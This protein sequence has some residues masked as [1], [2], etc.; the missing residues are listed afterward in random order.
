[1][2][3]PTPSDYQEAVQNP[4][5]NFRDAELCRA[6]PELNGLGLPRPVSGGFASVYRLHTEDRDWAVR[7]FLK[8]V[9]N[10]QQRYQAIHAHL[11]QARLPYFVESTYLPDGIRVMGR[12]YPA[13]KMAWVRGEPL[14]VHLMRHLG[15]R[16][17]LEGLANRWL[18]LSDGLRHAGIAHGDL[19]HGNILVASGQFQLID[20]DGMFVPALQGQ[21]SHEL[22][23]RHYQ[24]PLRDAIQFDGALDD[25]SVW[26]IFLSILA[27]ARLPASWT[28][29]GAGDD[30]LLFC[31]RDFTDA[32]DSPAFSLLDQLAD[33]ALRKLARTFRE[34]L[35]G[36][37]D[38]PPRWPTAD[39]PMDAY[40]PR[41]DPEKMPAA[42]ERAGWPD[43]LR[44]H[45]DPSL[46]PIQFDR[47]RMAAR[48]GVG[49]VGAV[50][51]GAGV[52][53]L[54]GALTPPALF[55]VLVTL[56]TYA[57]LA[58]AWGFYRAP[59][60]NARRTVRAE[61]R[62]RRRDLQQAEGK[63]AALARQ[64]SKVL[65]QIA[66][67]R[68]ASAR[69][70]QQIAH[71]LDADVQKQMTRFGHVED[72]LRFSLKEIAGA[73][74]R[75]LA[76]ALEELRAQRIR[77]GLLQHKLLPGR[78]HGVGPKLVLQLQV[79]GVRSARDVNYERL[80]RSPGV[81]PV[82][83]AALATWRAK[84]ER[85]LWASLPATLD[86]PAVERLNAQ[87]GRQRAQV[88]RDQTKARADHERTLAALQSR[89]AQRRQENQMKL[90]RALA[91]PVR[92]L[93][94]LDRLI[95][96]HRAI[97]AAL[98]DL[99]AQHALKLTRYDRITPAGYLRNLIGVG[100]S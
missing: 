20:Y 27:F 18:A 86:A 93:N 17:Y 83:A 29:S 65:R 48:I 85:E 1:M 67:R 57:L 52:I 100:G 51:V 45:L 91:E 2:S 14:D 30:R 82:R 84:L 68:E 35:P 12:W 43:W 88:E 95:G 34:S 23:H 24:S 39:R 89:D 11:S 9:P 47:P 62:K 81:G 77:E 72:R 37:P 61:L 55:A 3:W 7:C 40:L 78:V 16:P 99:I 38:G 79:Q 15:D 64:R 58:F 28:K 8:D 53:A 75:A 63:I 92:R 87:F 46:Q 32:A 42:S 98:S 5:L 60:A 90:E 41:P 59:Q 94:D 76:L 44:D 71:R 74:A 10:Q 13:Q 6:L 73:E 54:Q 31:D 49:A 96:E 80:L 21:T 33:P 22:G 25:F 70:E 4:R 56:N 36:G 69:A 50:E 26:V 66:D 97:G 19:Q